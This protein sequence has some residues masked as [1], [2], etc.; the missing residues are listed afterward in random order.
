MNKIC[1]AA[2][3]ALVSAGSVQ[4]LP[5]AGDNEIAPERGVALGGDLAIDLALGQ[6]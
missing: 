4:A 5:A 6:F 3:A 1:L 2:A